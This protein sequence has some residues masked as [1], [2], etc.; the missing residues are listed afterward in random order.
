MCASLGKQ[1]DFISASQKFKLNTHCVGINFVHL[2]HKFIPLE[3]MEVFYE[4]AMK[5]LE[6]IISPGPHGVIFL[7]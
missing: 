1:Q 7:G 4:F 6:L 2:T 5:S 3:I